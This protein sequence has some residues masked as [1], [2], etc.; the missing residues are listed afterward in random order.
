MSVGRIQWYRSP[1]DRE[2]LKELTKKSDVKPLL[3]V[4]G[5]LLI[6]GVL[7]FAAF[8]FYQM[9]LWFPM[10]IAAYIYGTVFR[11]L[12]LHT[13]VHELSHGTVFRTKTLN[14]FFFYFF[15]FF[16]W[17]NPLHFRA[18]HRLHHQYTV[19]R[20]LDKEI[21]QAPVAN[22]LN[23]KNLLAWFT[24]DIQG[25]LRFFGTNLLHAAG[26]GEADVFHWDPLFPEGS[27]QRRRMIRWARFMLIGHIVLAIFFGVMGWWILIY[28]V[29][30]SSFVGT[31]ACRLSVALQHTGLPENIPDWRM[32][33][34]TVEFGP[35]MRFLYWSMNYHVEHHMYAA[36]PFYNLKKLHRALADDL[37]EPIHGFWRGVRHMFEIKRRQ[38]QNPSYVFYPELPTTA[39][40]VNEG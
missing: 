11:F 13:A 29:S 15:S 23:W 8:R 4:G 32:L 12:S 31:W 2:I 24:F 21:V 27:E 26:D 37:P 7:G 16:T 40:P 33:A 36:V 30:F 6:I 22:K 14:E 39:A 9:R 1:I 34:R 28:L 35:V 25:F 38:R 3:H 10:I 19:H 17:S 20:G 5:F 18:S